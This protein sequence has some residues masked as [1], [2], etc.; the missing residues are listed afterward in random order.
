MSRF[1]PRSPALRIAALVALAVVIGAVYL[2]LQSTLDLPSRTASAPHTIDWHATL[3][4]L[5]VVAG[6]GALLG[7]FFGSILAL[8]RDSP[9]CIVD[10]PWLRSGLCAAFAVLLVLFVNGLRHAA[11]A[12]EVLWLAALVGAL[13]GWLGWTWARIIEH[14][15]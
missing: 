6:F 14:L 1:V 9:L 8:D 7:G 11:P 10:R 5:L 3:A 15:P 13:L 4:G 2:V 12:A